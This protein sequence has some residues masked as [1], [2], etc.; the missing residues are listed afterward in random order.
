MLN[1]HQ[2][3]RVLAFTGL[4]LMLSA[5][6]AT[7]TEADPTPDTEQALPARLPLNELRVFAEAFDRVSSAYVEEIDDRTL[8]E[9]ALKGLLSVRIGDRKFSKV[10]TIQQLLI[11]IDNVVF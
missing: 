2:S 9:N 1:T 4:A 5:A 7:D 11:Y 6:S 3:I 10:S 8:L